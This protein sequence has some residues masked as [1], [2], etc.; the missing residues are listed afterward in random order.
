MSDT[1]QVK[2]F[3]GDTNCVSSEGYMAVRGEN[4]VAFYV[5]VRSSPAGRL[6]PAGTC[7]SLVDHKTRQ[8]LNFPNITLGDGDAIFLDIAF[9]EFEGWQ[10]HSVFGGKT[11]SIC[12]VKHD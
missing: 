9:P 6:Y 1:V 10:V 7:R 8:S 3:N 4:V 2:V 11:L 5:D 12:L